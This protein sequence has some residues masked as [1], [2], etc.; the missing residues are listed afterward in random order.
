MNTPLILEEALRATGALLAHGGQRAAIVVVGATSLILSRVIHRL[1]SDVDV[2]ATAGPL[3]PRAPTRLRR[4][5][6][7]P[8]ALA[9]AV[10]TV[11]RDLGLPAT[12]LN[13]QVAGQWETGLPRGFGSR[14]RWRR[15]GGLWVGLAGRRDLIFLKL[16][17]AADDVGPQSRHFKDLAALRPT[18]RELMAACRWIGGQDPSPAMAA[19]VKQVITHVRQARR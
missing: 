2:I 9:D 18:A 15:Y 8:R 11:A 3:G 5:D 1:T 16:Y 7:L 17:A 10:T 12:W 14:V 19:A 6:P 13:T 4:P